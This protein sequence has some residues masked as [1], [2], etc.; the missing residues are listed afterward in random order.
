MIEQ[1]KLQMME[2]TGAETRFVE[3]SPAVPEPT[4]DGKPV[5]S[6]HVAKCRWTYTKAQA[7][8]S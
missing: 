4:R 8:K 6:V 3:V 5:A 2:T 7:L 1:Q